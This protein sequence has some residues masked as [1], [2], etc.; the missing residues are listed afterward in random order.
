MALSVS[1]KR[2]LAIPAATAGFG[3]AEVPEI[4]TPK[5]PARVNAAMC[6]DGAK[7]EEEVPS[8]FRKVFSFN[9]F[10]KMQSACLHAVSEFNLVQPRAVSEFNLV[11]P[12]VIGAPGTESQKIAQV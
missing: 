11:Q 4:A 1:K 12:R 8:E 6:I 10:N 2:R 7:V 5:T 3:D 9:C